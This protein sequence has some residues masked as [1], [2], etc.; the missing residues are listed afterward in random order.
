MIGYLIVGILIGLIPSATAVLFA[1]HLRAQR[2][3]AEREVLG[4]RDRLGG[5]E[6][7]YECAIEAGKDE[8]ERASA[9]SR[10]IRQLQYD[11][12]RQRDWNRRVDEG[13]AA[14]AAK[15]DGIEAIIR[16]G[17]AREEEQ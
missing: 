15:F 9:N 14:R 3:D 16:G 2:D 6:A 17:D 5:L 1:F 8:A 7:A 11:L 13:L 10:M 4:L 12:E